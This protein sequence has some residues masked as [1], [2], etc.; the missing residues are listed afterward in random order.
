M[1]GDGVGSMTSDVAKKS[2][3]VLDSFLVS[4]CPERAPWGRQNTEKRAQTCTDGPLINSATIRDST[5]PTTIPETAIVNSTTSCSAPQSDVTVPDRPPQDS[6]RWMAICLSKL[7]SANGRRQQGE[8][9]SM[10]HIGDSAAVPCLPMRP[11][12]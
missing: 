5:R 2:M 3:S 12:M 7:L 8:N 1:D 4:S 6:K 9:D 10:R 11:A